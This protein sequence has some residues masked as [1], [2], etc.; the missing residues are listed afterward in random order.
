MVRFYT[1]LD[2]ISLETRKY[3]FNLWDFTAIENAKEVIYLRH[4]KR[5]G[6][7]RAA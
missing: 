6:A 7:G 1:S 3:P 2:F 4:S 5:K